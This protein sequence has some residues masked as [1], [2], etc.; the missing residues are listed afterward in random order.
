MLAWA[1]RLDAIETDAPLDTALAGRLTVA[2]EAAGYR[3]DRLRE[4][5]SQSA[6][7]ATKATK[8]RLQRRP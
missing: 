4:L 1:L 8:A 5:L 2:A 3:V 7:K 6:P